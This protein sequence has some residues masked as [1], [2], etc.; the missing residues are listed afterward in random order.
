MGFDW[1]GHNITSVEHYWYCYWFSRNKVKSN[2]NSFIRSAFLLSSLGIISLVPL[3]LAHATFFGAGFNELH[4]TALDQMGFK[5]WSAVDI[6]ERIIRWLLA[7]IGVIA[8]A[9]IIY[10]GLRLVTSRGEEA[11]MADAKRIL[12]WAVIGLV[13]TMLAWSIIATISNIVET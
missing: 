1:F 12:L 2:M 3:Q 9:A 13:I 11:A 4:V 6:I 10:A 7:L 8:V 5:D